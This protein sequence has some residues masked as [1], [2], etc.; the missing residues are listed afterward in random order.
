MQSIDGAVIQQILAPAAMIPACGLLLLSSS[1]RMNTVLARIRAFHSERL[2]VWRS[3]E[4]SGTRH[5]R[6]RELRLEG[7]EH[8]THRLLRRAGLLRL[9]MLQLFV[10]VACNVLAVIGLA[11]VYTLSDAS[12]AGV[13]GVAIGV[14]VV[15]L[16]CMLGAM[17]TSVL[18]VARILETVRYEHVRVERLCESPEPACLRASPG[19]PESGD[20]C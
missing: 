15:G 12:G 10:A 6:V 3:E 11:L 9:T 20:V 16:L 13:Y 4:A 5:G 8:Q 7:L 18:E 19:E 17:G 2:D 1:A 14:F